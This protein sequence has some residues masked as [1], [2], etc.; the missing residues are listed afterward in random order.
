MKYRLHELSDAVRN[1]RNVLVELAIGNQV[2]SH[3]HTG[4]LIGKD[5]ANAKTHH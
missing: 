4:P 2:A 3:R 5:H 1:R